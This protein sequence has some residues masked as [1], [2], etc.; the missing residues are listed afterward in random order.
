MRSAECR[1]DNDTKIIRDLRSGRA[2]ASAVAQHTGINPQAVEIILNQ[3]VKEEHI[4][5]KP[6]GNLLVYELN[7]KSHHHR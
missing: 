4:I 5:A 7:P 6:L 3:L 2:T 1:M